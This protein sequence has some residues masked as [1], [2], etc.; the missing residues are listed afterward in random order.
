MRRLVV[1]IIVAGLLSTGLFSTV[2]A[3]GATA[4][5]N[6]TTVIDVDTCTA[7]PDAGRLFDFTDVC[8]THDSCYIDQPYGSRAAARRQCDVEFYWD[9]VDSC[10]A[11]W[12]RRSQWL[13]RSGCYGV[14]GVYYLGVRALG[15]LAWE[16]GEPAPLAEAA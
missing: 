2:L 15:R 11:D 5:G 13:K 7:V 14:A 16:E 12:G 1:P 8:R 10:R 4:A 9:M 3:G 6:A